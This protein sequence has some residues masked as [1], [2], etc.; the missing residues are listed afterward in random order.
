[1]PQCIPAQ[2]L[3]KRRRRKRT[4]SYESEIQIEIEKEHMRN[5]FE[6][7]KRMELNWGSRGN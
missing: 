4:V 5:T 7:K 3:K 6:P 2:Q 1:M